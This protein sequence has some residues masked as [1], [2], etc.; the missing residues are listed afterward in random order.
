MGC[1]NTLPKVEVGA[2]TA[3]LLVEKVSKIAGSGGISEVAE[4]LPLNWYGFWHW[5]V[6]KIP[7]LAKHP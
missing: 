3:M 6:V 5:V 2:D 7:K 4:K 1:S